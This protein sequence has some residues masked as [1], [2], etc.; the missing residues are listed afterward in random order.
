M[1]AIPRVVCGMDR[2]T[3]ARGRDP[4]CFDTRTITL[5]NRIASNRRVGDQSSHGNHGRPSTS[6]ATGADGRWGAGAQLG[7]GQLPRAGRRRGGSGDNMDVRPVTP[8][9]LLGS[10]GSDHLPSNMVCVLVLSCN[11]LLLAVCS[12]PRPPCRQSRGGM[13]RASSHALLTNQRDNRQ[14]LHAQNAGGERD[15][16]RVSR[17]VMRQR[18]ASASAVRAGCVCGHHCYT[19]HSRNHLKQSTRGAARIGTRVDPVTGAR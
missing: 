1:V 18:P 14:L 10:L 4:S 12:P 13:G 9:A 16:A 7:V 17:P 8:L 19:Q 5:L 6:G 15:R 11:V 2:Y 3:G